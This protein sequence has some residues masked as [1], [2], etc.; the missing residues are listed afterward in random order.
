MF[1]FMKYRF[2]YLLISGVLILT[3]VVSLIMW[4]LQPSIDFTG[5]S[6]LEIQIE[7]DLSTEEQKEIIEGV[8]DEKEIGWSTVQASGDSGWLIRVKPI[9]EAT[10]NKVVGSIQEKSESTIEELRF[11]VV[12]PTVGKEITQKTIVAVILAIIAILTYI[13]WSSRKAATTVS[14]WK[15][16]LSAVIAL[17]HDSIILIGV[18]S[19]LGHFLN[20]EVDLLLVT[21]ILTTM[22]FS[23]H[24]TIVVFDRIKE[25]FKKQPNL[26]LSSAVNIS[27]TETM[28][29]SVNNSM[30]IIFMLLSLSL[31]GGQTIFYFV[32]A[33]L[34]GTVLGTYSSP[35]VATPVL[36]LLESFN[37]KKE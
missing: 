21:A 14:A 33:L 34:V 2:I 11:E 1:D 3:S 8:L 27:L 30:T 22:S 20:V 35:F 18:F 12:G 29:R 19:I 32:I 17:L 15:F 4:G 25:T 37:R 36:L 26:D 24:D 13:A 16:G 9:E 23:V 10:K 7:S 6:L 28:T 31:L 5:G